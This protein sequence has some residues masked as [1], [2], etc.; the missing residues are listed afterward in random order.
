MMPKSLSLP[1]SS[2]SVAKGVG[3]R[4]QSN[5]NPARFVDT[6]TARRTSANEGI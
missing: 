2:D 1:L 4:N 3:N 5:S 6:I